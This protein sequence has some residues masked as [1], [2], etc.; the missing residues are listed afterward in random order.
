VL[1][2]LIEQ[3]GIQQQ[4]SVEPLSGPRVA[5]PL[6]QSLAAKASTPNAALPLERLPAVLHSRIGKTSDTSKSMTIACAV[7]DT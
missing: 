6:V 7:A 5:P 2:A 4:C 3:P 1:R